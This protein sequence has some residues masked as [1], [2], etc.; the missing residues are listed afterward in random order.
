MKRIKREFSVPRTSQQN[1]IAER[2]NT[3][4]IKAARTMLADSFWAEAVNTACY[5]QNRVL[6][7]KP[8]NKTLY[9]VLHGRTPS[10]G[11]MRHFGCPVTIFNTLDPLGKFDGKVDEGFLVGYSVNSKA[12][13]EPE[14]EGRKPESEVYVSPSSGAQTK[15]HDDK[16]K[17]EAKGKKPIE[18]ST[19]YRNLSAEFEDFSN[20]SIN[21]DNAT[22]TLVPAVGQI[23]TNSTNYLDI[24]SLH[25]SSSSIISEQL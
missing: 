24:S 12:F 8:Q 10:I 18:S 19:G 11:F 16:T 3:T 20:N 14:F 1:G 13:R 5:V 2:K 25:M 21:E 6:V 23:S 7:T 17:R 15:K 22:G 4:L 9:E